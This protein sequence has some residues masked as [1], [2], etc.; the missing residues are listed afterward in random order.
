MLIARATRSG[1]A[2]TVSIS[3]SA[4]VAARPIVRGPV[5]A[6]STGT[7]GIPVSPIHP[8]RLVPAP[9][10]TSAPFR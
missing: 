2:P 9:A 5:A 3:R 6:T 1:S 7:A 10:R 8:I 4:A